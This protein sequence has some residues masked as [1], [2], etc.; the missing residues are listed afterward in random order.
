MLFLRDRDIPLKNFRKNIDGSLKPNSFVIPG[1]QMKTNRSIN[2][3]RKD[4][5]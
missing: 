3:G 4:T 5:Q 1:K 2:E